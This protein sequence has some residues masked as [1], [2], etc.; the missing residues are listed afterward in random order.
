MNYQRAQTHHYSNLVVANHVV[1][2]HVVA[3]FVVVN[4]VQL[5]HSCQQ[6]YLLLALTGKVIGSI[7]QS[8]RL[9]LLYFLTDL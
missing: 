7:C 8:V 2:N 1:A 9:F 6:Y 4:S 3:N 5:T